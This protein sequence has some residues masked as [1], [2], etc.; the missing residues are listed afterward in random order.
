VALHSRVLV[1]LW[2]SNGYR[3]LFS[4]SEDGR[5]MKLTMHIYENFNCVLKALPVA[6]RQNSK[7][8]LDDL[9]V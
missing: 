7:Y 4:W 6:K 8:F 2:R 3:D 1:F 9:C 5:D